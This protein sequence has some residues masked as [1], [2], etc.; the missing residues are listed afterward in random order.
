MSGQKLLE[1]KFTR[2]GARLKMSDG[3]GGRSR[4]ASGASVRLDIRTDRDGEFFEILGG[5]SEDAG[6]RCWTSSRPT[7]ICY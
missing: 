4:P 2:I 6:S 7:G 5:S 3:V 1:A